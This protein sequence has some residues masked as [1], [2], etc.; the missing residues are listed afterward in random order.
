MKQYIAMLS[1]FAASAFAQDACTA[2]SSEFA[3]I[4]SGVTKTVNQ[5]VLSNGAT[6]SGQFE[7]IVR[8]DRNAVIQ[9]LGAPIEQHPHRVVF[10]L[11]DECNGEVVFGVD[12]FVSGY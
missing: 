11:S 1:V 10:A 9:R 7:E 12:G 4:Q 8:L 2:F 6:V 5:K 3:A